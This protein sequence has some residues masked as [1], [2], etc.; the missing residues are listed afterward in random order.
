MVIP[1]AW[2]VAG[3]VECQWSESGRG[4]EVWAYIGRILD[5]IGNKESRG[6]V[7]DWLQER[8]AVGLK[9][10]TLVLHANAL[11]GFARSLGERSI[12]QAARADVSAYVNNAKGYRL[13]SWRCR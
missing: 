8:Q 2:T 9:P 7:H 3:F 10:S 11:R 5:T 6:I 4:H 1:S 13:L 12:R